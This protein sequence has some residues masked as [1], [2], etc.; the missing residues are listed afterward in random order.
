VPPV[1]GPVPDVLIAIPQ[2]APQLAYPRLPPYY[3]VAGVEAVPIGLDLGAPRS[4]PMVPP[5][6]LE[7]NL[8]VPSIALDEQ[9]GQSVGLDAQL[10]Q[11]VGLDKQLGQ[12]AGLDKQL[13]QS[14]LL[15]LTET[16]KRVL[17]DQRVSWDAGDHGDVLEN[18]LVMDMQLN[19]KKGG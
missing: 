1:P 2:V 3:P 7:T 15:P 19:G 17:W 13:G 18:E 8:L 11:S 14:D 16:N 6:G 4:D 12:S 9:L 5:I 10:G